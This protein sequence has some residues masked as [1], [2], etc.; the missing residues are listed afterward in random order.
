MIRK[1]RA[2]AYYAFVF[3]VGFV[4]TLLWIGCAGGP[5]TDSV[6]G[7]RE[8]HGDNPYGLVVTYTEDEGRVHVAVGKPLGDGEQMFLRLRR[9]H[10]GH[11]DCQDVVETTSAIDASSG[12]ADL[13]VTDAE[14]LKPFYGPEWQAEQPTSEM[15]AAA[16]A[17]VDRIIDTCI[18]GSSGEI[19]S[20]VETDFDVA[21]DAGLAAAAQ[22]RRLQS[23]AGVGAGA[24]PLDTTTEQPI[25]SV[26]KYAEACIADLGEIPFF[27]KT[28]DGTYT[29]YSCM[30]ST[31]IPM[32][33]TDASGHV[34]SP[35]GEVDKC[36]KPQY[37][38]SLCE[39]GPRVAER[40]NDEG[41]HWVLLCRKSV[42][43]LSSSQF[44]DM[45]MIGHNPFT[46]KTCFFQNA[47][48]D[49]TDGAHVPHPADKVKSETLWSG[50]HGGVGSGI[51]CAHCHDNDPFIHSPWIDGALDAAGKPIVPKMGVDPDFALGYNDSPY[52]I[53]NSHGQ[54][55]TMERSLVS[56]EAAACTKCHR[57]GSGR[58]LDWVSRLD[59]TDE[60][61]RG[62]TSDEFLKFEKLH[63]MPP[64]LHAEA[65]TEANWAGSKFD[66]AIQFI[67]SCGSNSAGC[68]WR[69]LPTGP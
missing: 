37:I 32:T 50:V 61:F 51:E 52:T 59:G 2:V 20:A 40:T 10:F 22:A 39:Q 25:H 55:W 68:Q 12:G 26:Q 45:A 9:G 8:D 67:K 14:F 3:I 24:H 41:T 31:P 58:W 63:W 44:N 35:A 56:Q 57:I 19:T 13:T 66:K 16:R 38:Y 47:L 27:Q 6:S 17:G 4:A 21:W 15:I 11:L 5:S 33:V 1:L 34:E 60:Y 36:D 28:G 30:D 49:K 53:V 23:G 54:G 18:V 62:V 69:D 42:G 43:G 65:I 48:Y 46:G 29:T 7:G 64:D